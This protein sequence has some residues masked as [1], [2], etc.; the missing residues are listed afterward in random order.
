V[1][2]LPSLIGSNLHLHVNSSML[3]KM[4]CLLWIS[5]I[6]VLL[7]EH[8]NHFVTRG[9]TWVSPKNIPRQNKIKSWAWT[10]NFQTL[11]FSNNFQYILRCLTVWQINRCIQHRWDYGLT[12]WAFCKKK[13]SL[14]HSSKHPGPKNWVSG[15]NFHTSLFSRNFHLCVDSSTSVGP[16]RFFQI[17]E[18]S[19]SSVEHFIHFCNKGKILGQL[20][21]H[22]APKKTESRARTST[23]R[24]SAAASTFIFA[25]AA[26]TTCQRRRRHR[27]RRS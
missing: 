3:V 5:E 18:I 9:W 15:S 22:T 19:V 14:S 11:L 24:S 12:S 17:C 26:R 2:L 4:T 1:T 20:Q 8:H 23:R 6:W 7:V 25:P 21:K 27:R 10:F 16:T 13:S